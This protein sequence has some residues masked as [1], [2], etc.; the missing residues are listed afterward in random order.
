MKK[1]ALASLAV[2]VALAISPSVVNAQTLDFTYTFTYDSVDATGTLVGSLV[3]PGEYA[4]IGGTIDLTGSAINGTG[5]FSPILSNGN[6]YTGGGTILTFTPPYDQ[7]LYP[8][9]D[10][11]IDGNGALTFDIT[12]GLGAGN[13]L[14]IWSNGPG[15]YG[16]F[17]GNWTLGG[18]SS[19][20]ASF[21]ATAVPDGGTTLLLLGLAVAGLA[22][23]R[24]K[25]SA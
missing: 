10:P 1:F 24:R 5:V 8:G 21:S 3:A 9:A 12:S 4:I 7:D 13:G 25:L 18:Q 15:D 19:S 20:G 2:A 14:V 22:G 17:G 16:V 6:F 23:L 11:Q